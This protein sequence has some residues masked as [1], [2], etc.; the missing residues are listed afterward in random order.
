MDTL[1]DQLI[2]QICGYIQTSPDVNIE[3]NAFEEWCGENQ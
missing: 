1:V 3:V 2:A